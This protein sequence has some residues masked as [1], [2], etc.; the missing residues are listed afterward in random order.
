M[1]ATI[2]ENGKLTITPQSPLELYALRKWADGYKPDFTK[3]NESVLALDCI[4]NW[5]SP[6]AL[7]SSQNL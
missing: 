5:P 2:D 4:S 7:V 1:K 6:G 3:N